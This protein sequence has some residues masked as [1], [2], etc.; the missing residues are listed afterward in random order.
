MK[1][2]LSY[3][4]PHQNKP[5]RV[6][7]PIWHNPKSFNMDSH[8]TVMLFVWMCEFQLINIAIGGFSLSSPRPFSPP[9]ILN[10]DLMCAFLIRLWFLLS[11]LPTAPVLHPTAAVSNRPQWICEFVSCPHFHPELWRSGPPCQ[12]L[13]PS[14]SHID[15]LFLQGSHNTGDFLFWFNL[16]QF[17]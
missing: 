13:G 10:R 11:S 8:A 6:S 14:L 3:S 15:P 2:S 12:S 1:S 4:F 16:N 17:P 5:P 7:Q 9:R